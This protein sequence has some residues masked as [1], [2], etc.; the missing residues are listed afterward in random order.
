MM[1][2]DINTTLIDHMTGC[3]SFS[4]ALDESTALSETAQYAIFIRGVDKEFTA[5]EEFLT[6]QSLKGTTTGEEVQKVFISLG[7]SK[8]VGVCTDGATSMVGLRKGFIE[9]SN[10]KATELNVQRDDLIVLCSIHQQDLSSKS[11]R[12]HNESGSK[13]H[14]FYSIPRA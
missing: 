9:I 3:E 14:Q 4:I 12:L 1:A 5:T 10:E 13:N 7:L 11:I 6:L 2:Y 8:L